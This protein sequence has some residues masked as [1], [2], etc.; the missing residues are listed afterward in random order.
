MKGWIAQDSQNGLIKFFAEKPKKYYIDHSKSIWIW[1][2][3]GGATFFLNNPMVA[4]R[5]VLPNKAV[6]Y[7]H[8]IDML[9]FKRKK[10]NIEGF[11][12]WEGVSTKEP[13]EVELKLELL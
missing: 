13:R 11:G 1:V 12:Q 6:N 9:G 4:N 3:E 7:I 10:D 2:V 5:E 8:L